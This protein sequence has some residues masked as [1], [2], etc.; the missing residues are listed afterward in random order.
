MMSS[1][2]G[3]EII[4]YWL[5]TLID[6]LQHYVALTIY[7]AVRTRRHG[8]DNYFGVFRLCPVHICHDMAHI[9][10]EC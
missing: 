4:L 1:R 10:L 5:K 3:Y 8:Y 9:S 6:N 7:D 2:N